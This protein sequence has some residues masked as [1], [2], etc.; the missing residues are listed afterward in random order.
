LSVPEERGN[1]PSVVSAWIASDWQ[2]FYDERA[3]IRQHDGYY[4]KQEAERLAWG[5]AVNEWHKRHGEQVPPTGCAGRLKP[6]GD[7]E[8]VLD[9]ADG[10]RTH[11]A[12]GFDCVIKYGD[13]WR[14][15][16]EKALV[17]MGLVPPGSGEVV[18]VGRTVEPGPDLPP[19]SEFTQVDEWLR[20]GRP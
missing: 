20:R 16:A 3:A 8:E 15:A 17:E 19:D 12:D 4:T 5:E 6:I 7:G 13:K 10:T 1:D 11:L 18:G 2:R 14:G 9:H